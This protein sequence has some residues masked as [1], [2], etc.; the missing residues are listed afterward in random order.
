[1]DL[2]H[3]EQQ[4]TAAQFSNIPTLHELQNLVLRRIDLATIML[5]QQRDLLRRVS[6]LLLQRS[7]VRD[8]LEQ[9]ETAMIDGQP[10]DD[11]H[12]RRFHL[13]ERLENGDQLIR[14]SVREMVME[15]LPVLDDILHP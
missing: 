7:R 12:A 15:H 14:D 10:Q 8:E 1:M 9:L 3:E 13:Q 11:F 4:L 6:R 5:Q 2:E